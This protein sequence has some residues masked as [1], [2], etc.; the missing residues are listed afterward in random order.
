MTKHAAQFSSLVLS[1]WLI[2][3]ST[4]AETWQCKVV[5]GFGERYSGDYSNATEHTF[6]RATASKYVHVYQDWKFDEDLNLIVDPIPKTQDLQV[7]HTGTVV[8]L[9]GIDLFAYSIDLIF[10]GKDGPSV[11]ISQNGADFPFALGGSCEVTCS[12]SDIERWNGVDMG[13][14][15]KNPLL[16]Q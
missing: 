16:K 12:A 6:T 4:H 14:K 10:H 9:L 15:S 5:K 7:A 11:T 3:G 13:C 8:A 1:L 2:S